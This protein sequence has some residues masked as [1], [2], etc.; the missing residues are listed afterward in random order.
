MLV[1][2]D[3]VEGFVDVDVA[4]VIRGDA[5]GPA[6][7]GVVFRRPSL[8][9]FGLEVPFGVEAEC[10]RRVSGVGPRGV[11]VELALRRRAGVV[12]CDLGVRGAVAEEVRGFAEFDAADLVGAGGREVMGF[13]SFRPSTFPV[14]ARHAAVPMFDD[15]EVARGLIDRERLRG[16]QGAAADVGVEAVKQGGLARPREAHQAREQGQQESDGQRRAALSGLPVLTG[17]M[18]PSI[19]ALHEVLSLSCC[20]ARSPKPPRPRC[21]VCGTPITYLPD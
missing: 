9:Q 4:R 7:A 21:P 6:Q 17:V 8:R 1:F 11:D 19:G 12:D 14:V 13:E 10:H 18:V 5:A 15:V 2:L 3:P 16:R 20:F